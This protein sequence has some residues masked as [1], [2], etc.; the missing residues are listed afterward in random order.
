M[1]GGLN[2]YATASSA[3]INRFSTCRT[4]SPHRTIRHRA[5]AR[6]TLACAAQLR[7]VAARWQARHLFTS[8]GSTSDWPES[9]V[10]QLSSIDYRVGDARAYGCFWICEATEHP[11]EPGAP[12]VEPMQAQPVRA[13]NKVA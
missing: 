8:S 12:S 4:S 1:L 5:T 7:I 13:G 2:Q 11:S 10:T 9:T 3:S 6:T